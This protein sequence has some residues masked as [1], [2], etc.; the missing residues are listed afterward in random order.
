MAG[1]FPPQEQAWGLDA[2]IGL[3]PQARAKVCREASQ[4]SFDQAARTINEDWGT[5]YDG[6]QMQR[7]SEHEGQKVVRRRIMKFGWVTVHGVVRKT[8]MGFHP[9]QRNIR[10]TVTLPAAAWWQPA[11]VV[12]GVANPCA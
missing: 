9:W 6:K 8:A 3:T 12:S 11:A 4:L 10:A 1:L 7:W 5:S 2:Q